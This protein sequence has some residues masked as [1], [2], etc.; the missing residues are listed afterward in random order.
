MLA[1]NVSLDTKLRAFQYKLLYRII[2]TN[3]KLFAF[4]IVD[5]PV[6][7]FCESEDEPLEH[8]FYFCNVTT[9][10]WKVLSW[11]AI[12]NKELEFTFKDIFFGKFDLDKDFMLINH[13]LLL[14]KLFIYRCKIDKIVPSFEI[15]KAKLKANYNL[16][17]LLQ[18]KM[19]LF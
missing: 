15:F 8:M 2:F 6:C 10:F 18:G 3:D 14:A 19:V 7:T 5:S 1:F 11:I 16:D 4:K 9:L 12:Y 13:I 17:S